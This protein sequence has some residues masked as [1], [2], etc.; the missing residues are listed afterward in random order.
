[1]SDYDYDELIVRVQ[2]ALKGVDPYRPWEVDEYRDDQALPVFGVFAA[3]SLK[4]ESRHKETAEFI[5]AAPDL[6]HSLVSALREAVGARNT[7]TDQWRA[8]NG[9]CIRLMRER[10]ELK[11]ELSDSQRELAS[12]KA[13]VERLRWQYAHSGDHV[14]DECWPIDDD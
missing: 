7:F 8:M 3:D 1:M 13:E 9:D 5:A 4:A 12:T 14:C 6:I 2:S 11:W 10:T